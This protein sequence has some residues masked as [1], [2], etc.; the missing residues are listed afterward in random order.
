MPETVKFESDVDS[1]RPIAS[2]SL[3]YIAFLVAQYLFDGRAAAFLPAGGV[4]LLEA[5]TVSV[6]TV[7]FLLYALVRTRISGATSLLYA[8]GG[9]SALGLPF[10][11]L[12]PGGASLYVAGVLTMLVLG[13]S[14][15]AAHEALAR[16]F[17]D[18][19]DVARVVGAA[20]GAGVVA[21]CVIQAVAPGPIALAA[22]AALPALAAPVLAALCI[23]D[24][25]ADLDVSEPSVLWESLG[26]RAALLAI[27]IALMTCVFSTLNVNLTSAHAAG[28]IDLGEWTRLFL[29]VSAVAAGE[30]LDRL[31]HRW[32]PALMACV[33]TLAS[34]AIFAMLMGAP[35]VLATVVFYL[36]SGFFVVFFTSSFMLMARETGRYALWSG[37]GRAVN[38][39]TSLLVAAPALTLVGDGRALAEAGVILSILAA[40]LAVTF[41]LTLGPAPEPAL[42]LMDDEPEM[43]PFLSADNRL[44][45]FALAF[46]LTAREAE[47]L[48]AMVSSR[49]S[50]QELVRGLGISRTAFYRHVSSMA[51][52]TGTESR[53]ELMHFYFDWQ[54]GTSDNP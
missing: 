17:A 51:E 27:L 47:V 8:S 12:A 20:Y 26:R 36:G 52:K 16:R 19:P 25:G 24:E 29:A 37:M 6:S 54:P 39:A 32:E 21:Q 10:C 50:V 28:L 35:L 1:V 40:M 14:G 2:L 7:G 42:P 22:F 53:V 45:A 38:S 31:E 33:T 23:E 34:F 43:P 48:E 13:F 44:E 11:A 3:F 41:L 30:V 18:G 46:G 9:L 4:A 49:Q 15:A 5:V